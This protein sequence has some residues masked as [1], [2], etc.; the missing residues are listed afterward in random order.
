MS[1]KRLLTGHLPVVEFRSSLNLYFVVFPTLNRELV[2]GF[3]HKFTAY[4]IALNCFYGTPFFQV[5][6]SVPYDTPYPR[7]ELEYPKMESLHIDLR[8][9]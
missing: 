8:I 1:D 3:K 2:M 5:V 6:P 7:P 9:R 4:E